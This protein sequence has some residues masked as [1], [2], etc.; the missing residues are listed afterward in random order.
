MPC[1]SAESGVYARTGIRYVWMRA[2]ALHV[3]KGSWN[4]SAC[5]CD[6]EEQT[7]YAGVRMPEGE[8]EWVRELQGGGRCLCIAEQMGGAVE[9]PA[10]L[11]ICMGFLSCSFRS[12]RN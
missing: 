9:T 7:Q 6:A 8:Q 4:V 10:E 11:Q 1:A 3:Y 5:G 12:P 2:Q